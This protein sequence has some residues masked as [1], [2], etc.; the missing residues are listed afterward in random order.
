[1]AAYTIGYIHGHFFW[2]SEYIPD[3]I[4]NGVKGEKSNTN[5]ARSSK[6]S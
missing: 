1:M 5:I 2:G 4:A 6:G 3:Q